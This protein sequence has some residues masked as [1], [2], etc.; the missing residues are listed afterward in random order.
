MSRYTDDPDYQ[1]GT[2]VQRQAATWLAGKGWFVARVNDDTAIAPMAQVW[3]RQVVLPDLLIA[4]DGRQFWCDVKY[5]KL[6]PDFRIFGCR[7]TGID[8]RN[9][10]EYLRAQ[11][12][13]GRP[14]VLLFVHRME[15]EVRWT[16]ADRNYFYGTGNGHSLVYWQYDRLRLDGTYAEIDATRP[17]DS[18]L[19]PLADLL[20]GTIDLQGRLPGLEDAA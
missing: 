16:L 4:K 9:H 3:K 18:R 20:G 2:N 5:K 15:N 17:D 7:T 14:V 11:A 12:H 13:T 10:E 19:V 6:A 1:S 8:R